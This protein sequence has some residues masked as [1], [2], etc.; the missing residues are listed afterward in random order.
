M[1]GPH[2]KTALSYTFILM[3]VKAQKRFSS[4]IIFTNLLIPYFRNGTFSYYFSKKNWEK[5]PFQK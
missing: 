5:F 2:A 1:N 3:P 4:K